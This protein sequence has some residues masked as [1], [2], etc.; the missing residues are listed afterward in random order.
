MHA[1]HRRP[2]AITDNLWP[3][4][5][6]FIQGLNFHLKSKQQLPSLYFRQL[7][8]TTLLISKRGMALLATFYFENQEISAATTNLTVP[9]GNGPNS[10][11]F[12]VVDNDSV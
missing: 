1:H 2:A 9:N 5:C 11:L 10:V 8:P 12:E 3:S 6:K 7:L 4:R